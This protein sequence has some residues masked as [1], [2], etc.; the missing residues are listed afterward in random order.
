MP[1]PTRLV[2]VE[3]R[4]TTERPVRSDSDRQSPER[5]AEVD[6]WIDVESE[7]LQLDGVL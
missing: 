2:K 7:E 4:R 5:K 6:F 1:V 3:K